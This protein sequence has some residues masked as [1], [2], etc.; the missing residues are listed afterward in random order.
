MPESISPADLSRKIIPELSAVLTKEVG[1]HV[2]I[3]ILPATNDYPTLRMR[4]GLSTIDEPLFGSPAAA[5]KLAYKRL[6]QSLKLPPI[7]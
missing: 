1:R 6:R 2:T 3:E 4:C 5:I 7:P